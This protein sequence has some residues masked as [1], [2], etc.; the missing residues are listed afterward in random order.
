MRKPL[1]RSKACWDWSAREGSSHTTKGEQ[2]K[3]G[4]RETGKDGRKERENAGSGA[5]VELGLE[6][7]WGW[8]GEW[9]T[10]IH[11]GRGGIPTPPDVSGRGHVN[12]DWV[13]KY[14]DKDGRDRIPGFPLSL[15]ELCSH[16]N[17]PS[18][19]WNDEHLWMLRSN[20]WFSSWLLFLLVVVALSS[21][22]AFYGKGAV[23]CSP[24]D[25]DP[26]VPVFLL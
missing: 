16:G 22:A 10:A 4:E 21:L 8:D 1:G 12:T 7:G 24:Q 20:G 3:P 2:Q 26:G 11:P 9:W 14:L 17:C 23:F 19:E 25:A 18:R 15:L 6:A 13:P 5:W